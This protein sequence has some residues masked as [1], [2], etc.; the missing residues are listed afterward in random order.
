MSTREELHNADTLFSDTLQECLAMARHAQ[1]SG[2]EVKGLLLQRLHCIAELGQAGCKDTTMQELGGIHQQLV[3]AISPASPRTVLL[4]NDDARA[5]PFLHHFGAVPLMRQLMVAALI[6]LMLLMGLSLFSEV[7]G[8]PRNTDI[9]LASGSTLLLNELFLLAAAGVGASFVNLFKANRFIQENTFDPKYSGA[10]W[11]RFVLGLIAGFIL[12]TLIELD[13]PLPPGSDTATAGHDGF[14]RP[15]L[16]MV[17]GFSASVV[18]RILSRIAETVESLFR[19][20]SR[21]QNKAQAEVMRKE[22][23]V[24]VKQ[25]QSQTAHGLIEMLGELENSDPE[26][27]RQQIKAMIAELLGAEPPLE[28]KSEKG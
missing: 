25:Q 19:G 16:A 23:D 26:S 10:Y 17:G 24:E 6:S 13:M 4:L 12:A 20:D 11:T 3:K 28:R 15:L 2:H 18:Y 14:A 1:S 21:E 9:L 7:D 27:Q 8:S 22:M 5:H